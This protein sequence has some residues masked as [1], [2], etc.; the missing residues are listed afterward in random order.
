MA[1][2][3]HAAATGHL[4]FFITAPGATDTLYNVMVV[5]VLVIIFLLGSF[6][7]Q[8]HALPERMAHR[9]SKTQM[10]LVA[11]LALIALFTHQHIFWIGA[12]LLALVQFP[13][14]RTPVVSIADS[15]AHMAE[16]IDGAAPPRTVVASPDEGAPAASSPTVAIASPRDA[17]ARPSSNAHLLGEPNA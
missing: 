6:Y 7:F 17:D 3:V 10:Q 15:L 11:V 5:V 13:D 1:D 9:T 2:Q 8:L 12:L 4:P 14:F 16:R